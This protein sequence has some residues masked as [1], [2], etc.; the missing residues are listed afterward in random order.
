MWDPKWC[1][2]L[3]SV[4]CYKTCIGHFYTIKDLVVFLLKELHSVS[5]PKSQIISLFPL[6][7][8]LH[9]YLR[10]SETGFRLFLQVVLLF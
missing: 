6:L 2:S 8:T 7:S 1:I 3:T 9:F 10:K 5:G 4:E